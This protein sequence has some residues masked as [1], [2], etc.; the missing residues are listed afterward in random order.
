MKKIIFFLL[1]VLICSFSFAQK[2]IVKDK[3]SLTPI[4]GV[5]LRYN[6]NDAISTDKDGQVTINN[7][8][9]SEAITFTCI[10][11]KQTTISL[12][13][14]K[15]DKYVVYLVEKAYNTNEVVISANRFEESSEKLPQ[16]IAV[17]KSKSIA[18]N[19]LQTTADLLQNTGLV[20]VQ[21]SQAGGGSPMIRGFEAN[22]VLMV[23]DGV[24]MN[25][26]IYRGGHLQNVIT[27]DQSSLERMEILFGSG[28]LMYGSD[29]LGG[30]IHFYT[31]EPSL[32][33]NKKFV[34]G[35]S[36]YT[37]YATS[38]NERTA[39]ADISV[40][41]NMFGS[42]TS[43]TVSD[44]DNMRQG[45]NRSSDLGSLGIRN[46][47]QD[48]INGVDTMM[49]N[50]D[51]LVQKNSG[52]T[53]YDFMQKFIFKQSSKTTHILNFQYSSSTDIPRYDRL[54]EV[55]G[56][57][58]FKSAQW[59]YGPQERLMLSYQLRLSNTSIYDKAQITIAYQDIEESRHNRNWNSSKLNH[60]VENVKV[61]TLNADFDKI[62]K[63]YDV[64]YGTEIMY[65]DVQSKASAENIVTGAIS[66]LDTRYPNGGSYTNSEALY[67]TVSREL[68]EKIIL[69]G[70]LRIAHYHLNSKFTDKTFFPFP[71]DAIDQ[72][73]TTLTAQVGMV[74][75]PAATWKIGLNLSTG[76]RSPNVDDI[77]KVFESSK[78]DTI[79]SNSTVGTVIVPNPDLKAERTLNAELS[80]SKNIAEKI[81]VTGIVFG[82]KIHDGIVTQNS[83]FNG[84]EFIVYGDT[85]SRVQKNVNAGE[86]YIMGV[87]GII[88]YD[89]NTNFSASGSY[90]Y[91]YGRITSVNP[92][93]PLDHIA[94]AFGRV[95]FVWKAKKMR[96]ELF[97]VF[98]A[99]KE[100]KDYNLGGEDNLQYATVN[101][102]PAWYTINLRYSYQINKY[103]QA[104]VNLDNITDKAYRVFASGINSSGRSVGLTLRATF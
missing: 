25:N 23:V 28:S 65:N 79:G 24:R 83:T 99:A 31:K 85:V 86:A 94:P 21:K 16:Q 18:Q 57:G 70:G 97:S 38:N 72:N 95:S 12:I 8:I 22:K 92:E 2:I 11:Y 64:Q 77:A 44:F 98:N 81:Q 59:Y 4:Q 3:V 68:S 76:Y 48:R 26:A 41:N 61:Y 74:Y 49:R 69:S 32:S 42:L 20:N 54:T 35:G 80:I 101:G 58:T 51:S 66:P 87:S 27:M 103:I 10:G 84:S 14:L 67:T 7:T 43:L 93:T 34:L 78:G 9:K 15:K 75:K 33:D 89:I 46:F 90:N 47:Y 17:I 29:A 102:M 88:N 100:L 19:N 36:A 5:V 52:Y 40:A 13:E 56:S 45:K 73:N 53:Q 63:G 62:I 30:V 55:N 37:R 6:T 71:F 82:V 96:T 60:R 39:H 50:D 91:T 1:L 104:Q